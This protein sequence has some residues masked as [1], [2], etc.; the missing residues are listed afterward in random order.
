MAG[1]YTLRNSRFE[2]ASESAIPK[3]DLDHFDVR[4]A[5]RILHHPFC[6]ALA[7]PLLLAALLLMLLIT[8]GPSSAQD[9]EGA[10][11]ST[12][13]EEGSAAPAGLSDLRFINPRARIALPEP[14][15]G[16]VL[17]FVVADDFPPFA[18]LDGSG[19]LSGVHID[20]IRAVCDT[21]DLPCTLQA[22]R[23]DQVTA[24]AQEDPNNLV[25]AAGLSIT[26][27]NAER[28]TF[29]LPYY[30]FAARFVG[31]Q[32]A[33]AQ[34]SDSADWLNDARIGVV[35]NTAHAA[36]LRDAY[37]DTEI[38]TFPNAQA[39]LRAL[40]REDISHAFGDGVDLAIWLASNQSGD[41][42][43]F[44]GQPIFSVSY[45]GEGL[46]FAVPRGQSQLV[47]ALNAALIRLESSGEL[48][49]IML[50]A[51]PLDPLGL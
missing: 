45:F 47:Q 48:E 50:T 41:C 18:F 1:R 26:R 14:M 10:S 15:P 42:C 31:A 24:A 13:Q 3:L 17:R 46:A 23:F 19:R 51:F 34:T 9:G 4:M 2:L 37:A 5:V 6:M 16:P 27:Q 8:A 43:A 11:E 49:T 33:E 30:R 44:V 28:F 38:E 7:T 35:E 21:L 25:L 20:L 22:R 39:M 12:A 29:S 36:F 32:S 40:R